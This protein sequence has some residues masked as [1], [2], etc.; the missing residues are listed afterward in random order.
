MRKLRRRKNERETVK[1]MASRTCLCVC[2]CHGVC[3]CQPI[4]THAIMSGQTSQG[5]VNTE[6][7]KSGGDSSYGKPA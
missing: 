2:G 3:N 4:P 5:I 1:A 7:S 6:M